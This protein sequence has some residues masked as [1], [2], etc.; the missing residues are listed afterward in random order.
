MQ[1]PNILFIQVDQMTA[2]A[3]AAYGNPFSQTPHLDQ[4]AAAG[5]VFEN[6]YCNFPLCAP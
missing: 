6:A 3:L 5:A 2:G 1:L 4:I